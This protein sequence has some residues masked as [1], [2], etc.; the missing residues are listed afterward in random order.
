MVNLIQQEIYKQIILFS[1]YNIS[2]IIIN[3][4][5]SFDKLSSYFHIN[6][7]IQYFFIVQVLKKRDAL[8]YFYLHYID[9]FSLLN[10]S[11]DL[12]TFLIDTLCNSLQYHSTN[13]LNQSLIIIFHIITLLLMSCLR[14][15]DS[16]IKLIYSN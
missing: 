2:K 10:F 6:L 12:I 1:K 16:L 14:V 9:G 13:V 8:S 4:N 3:A 11:M 5:F 7:F 15:M